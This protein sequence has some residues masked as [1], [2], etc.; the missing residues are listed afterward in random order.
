M[1]DPALG[2]FHVQ[3][4]FAEKYF[5]FTPYQYGANNPILNID[6]NGD[7]LAVND[8]SK[9]AT[10]T[11]K[12]NDMV[13]KKT[14]GYYT[15]ETTAGGMTVLKSTGKNDSKNPISKE[16]QA[17]V[18]QF[19]NVANS[20]KTNTSIN[21]VDNDNNILVVDPTNA[22]ID[23]G[24]LKAV[25]DLN[26]SKS[27]SAMLMHEVVEQEGIQNGGGF[28][29]EL[30]HTDGIRAENLIDNNIRTGYRE[31]KTSKGEHI[32]MVGVKTLSGNSKTVRIF[33]KNKNIIGGWE[34]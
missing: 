1:Y 18:D 29:N 33:S 6:V 12:L 25:D 8:L 5:D 22:T 24:D 2:R 27:G 9:N 11:D 28:G 20:S 26:L 19:N 16:G 23:V 15:T 4:R 32:M 10:A 30:W 21:I 31:G 13:S 3:D 7:S 34:R 17:F 14:D